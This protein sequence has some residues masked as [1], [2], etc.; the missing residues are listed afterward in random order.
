MEKI[1]Y[2]H[3]FHIL[4]VGSL[5]FY[6]G[7]MKN[8]NQ[9]FIY[10]TLLGIGIFLIL[11]HSFKAYN[12][13]KQGKSFIINLFHI[14]IVSPLLIYIGYNKQMTDDLYFNIL[15][16]LGILAI[17]DHGYYLFINN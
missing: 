15:I 10:P 5:F 17:L 2:V 11:F 6:V 3:L 13:I 9:L 7:I 4:F 16:A 14:F 12:K 8:K 1:T